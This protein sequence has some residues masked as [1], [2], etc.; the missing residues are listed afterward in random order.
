MSEDPVPIA[1]QTP[2]KLTVR[3]RH[4]GQPA[5]RSGGKSI[6]EGKDA[7][8]ADG[9]RD[10]VN[11]GIGL[12]TRLCQSKGEVGKDK[13]LLQ[14]GVRAMDEFDS[15]GRN[16]DKGPAAEDEGTTTPLPEKVRLFHSWIS[17]VFLTFLE[18]MDFCVDG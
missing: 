14:V 7:I 12:E 10:I 6:K 18:S 11:P 16:G 5:K 17:V 15:G 9:D 1:H 4:R 3:T 13:D 8:E 2:V